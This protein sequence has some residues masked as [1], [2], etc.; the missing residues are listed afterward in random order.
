[1]A[2]FGVVVHSGEPTDPSLTP[3]APSKPE[4]SE[5][6]RTSA[7]LSWKSSPGAGMVP[8]SYLIEAFR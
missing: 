5:V 1:M 4:V 6:G 3:A 2:E 7:T 8:T